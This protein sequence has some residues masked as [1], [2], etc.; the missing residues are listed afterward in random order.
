MQI[1]ENHDENTPESLAKN[2]TLIKELNGN[3]AKVRGARRG[4][5]PGQARPGRALQA[6]PCAL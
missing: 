3:I 6:R 5:A 4:P 1:K 2:C